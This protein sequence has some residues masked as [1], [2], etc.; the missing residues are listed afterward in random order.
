MKG[1]G[2]LWIALWSAPDHHPNAHGQ[3]QWWF[4][5]FYVEEIF[6]EVA[7][8]LEG[9]S[10]AMSKADFF[11]VCLARAVILLVCLFGGTRGRGGTGG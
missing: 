1:E 8:Y 7:I 2:E 4:Q 6:L 5:N 3:S 10:E 9:K 11:F